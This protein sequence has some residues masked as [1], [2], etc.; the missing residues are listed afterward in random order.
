MRCLI[1]SLALMKPCVEGSFNPESDP[2][3]Q[4]KHSAFDPTS[5]KFSMWNLGQWTGFDPEGLFTSVQMDASGVTGV[6]QSQRDH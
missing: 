6:P 4:S 1:G 3:Q 5:V 2:D